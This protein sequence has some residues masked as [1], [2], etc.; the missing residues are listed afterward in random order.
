MVSFMCETQM[1]ALTLLQPLAAESGTTLPL[2][3]TLVA[4]PSQS[5]RT[6][7]PHYWKLITARADNAF[8]AERCGMSGTAELRA[9]RP[10]W[11]V[12]TPCNV[13]ERGTFPILVPRSS[14]K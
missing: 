2:A 7:S 5:L 13:S 11:G 10:V 1:V 9:E 8:Q 6:P 3:E 14:Y 4:H 12:D